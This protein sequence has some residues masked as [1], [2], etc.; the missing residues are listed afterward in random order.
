MQRRLQDNKVDTCLHAFVENWQN[1]GSSKLRS[2][3]TK[4][5]RMKVSY[6]IGDTHASNPF[7]FQELPVNPSA[8]ARSP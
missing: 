8:A 2:A 5:A 7:H 3:H 1:R 6:A 4:K